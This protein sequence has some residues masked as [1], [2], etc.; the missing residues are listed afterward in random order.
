[1]FARVTIVVYFLALLSFTYGCVFLGEVIA[2]DSTGVAVS[3]P[4]TDTEA[5]AGDILCSTP[6]G[7]KRCSKEFDSA[8]Y[9][10]VVDDPTV[11]IQDPELPD[12]KL[13]IRSGVA[14][15]NVNS[16]L[17]SIK[18]G[19]AVTSS[20]S[21]GVGVLAKGNGFVL[22]TAIDDYENTDA[23]ALGQVTVL[24]S[25]H[26]VTGLT[27][28]RV[29]L[30]ALLR[31]GLDGPILEPLQSLRY[32]LAVFIVLVSFILGIIYFGRVARAGVEAV[33]RNPLASRTIQFS[34]F[35]N[36]VLTILIVLIGLGIAYMILVL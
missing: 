27:S 31:N 33:G 25:P 15:V 6:E 10:V 5:K 1:M 13:V 8:I 24:V 11:F 4:V 19:E 18:S 16:T 3:V 32:V 36:I 35:I 22:G 17:G 29:N 28:N 34:V 30:L 9:G 7:I 20:T 2:Q 23:N 14:K 21:T 26:Y 12:T